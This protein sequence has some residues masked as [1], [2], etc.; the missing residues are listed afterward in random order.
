MLEIAV[1]ELGYVETNAY[2][3][4]SPETKEAVL[5]DAPGDSFDVVNEYMRKHKLN[6]K[7]LY[8]TH[9]HWDH[10]WDGAK[11]HAA[12]VKTF[13]HRADEIL[14]TDPQG[15][16]SR[17]FPMI[18]VDPVTIDEWLEDGQQIEILGES[19]EVR[20]VPGHCP[21]NILFYFKKEDKAIVGDAIFAGSI[22]RTDLPGGD[23]MTLANSIKKKI[24]TLPNDCELLPGHGPSTTVGWE[25][26]NNN[27]VHD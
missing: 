26:G 3:V 9:G 11:F 13:A 12:G 1:F 2:L 20:H 17:Y 18:K 19:V 16:T 6:L 21:G 27:F 24:Y 5:F 10:M 22:G 8:F 14:F 23:F 4:Y 25:R 7:A 15:S